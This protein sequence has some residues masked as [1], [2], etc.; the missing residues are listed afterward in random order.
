MGEQLKARVFVLRRNYLGV[1]VGAAGA[2]ISLGALLFILFAMKDFSTLA[3]LVLLLTAGTAYNSW[4]HEPEPA[5]VRANR[6]GLWIDARFLPASRIAGVAL[7][8]RD[9]GPVI[10]VVVRGA[11]S[12]VELIVRDRAQGERFVRL[13]QKVAKPAPEVTDAFARGEVAA[14]AAAICRGALSREAWVTR[15]QSIAAGARVSHRIAPLLPERLQALLV[16]PSAPPTLRAA[17]AIALG[18]RVDLRAV[19]AAPPKLRVAIE[20]AHDPARQG[21]L[22]ALLAE[23][24]REE[25]EDEMV[26]R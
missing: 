5:A 18:P 10:R 24:E 1:A 4:I 13:L 7:L 16:S 12:P 23:L 6:Q 3:G 9:P 20:V 22:S 21:E 8:G 26:L 15:L 14:E 19:T 11:L 2:V 25:E 17:A